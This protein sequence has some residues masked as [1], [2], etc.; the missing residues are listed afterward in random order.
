MGSSAVSAGPT[1]LA[2]FQ[3]ENIVMVGLF[4]LDKNTKIEISLPDEKIWPESKHKH[5]R[6][7]CSPTNYCLGDFP[8]IK[9]LLTL[10]G[11][12]IDAFSS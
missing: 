1:T 4:H 11:Q 7:F 2:G 9:V 5:R 12:S 8:F 3:Q 10:L 6:T